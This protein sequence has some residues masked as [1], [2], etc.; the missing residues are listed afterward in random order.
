MNE[1]QSHSRERPTPY[2]PA[3][4]EKGMKG[5]KDIKEMRGVKEMKGVK[6]MKGMTDTKGMKGMKGMMAAT[7]ARSGGVGRTS[8]LMDRSPSSH[9]GG[10]TDKARFRLLSRKHPI[11]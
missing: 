10:V 2:S 8:T 11:Y 3:R 7:V 1:V 5:M 6:D 9:L 4:I